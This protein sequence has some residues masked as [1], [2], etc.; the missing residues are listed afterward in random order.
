MKKY[1]NEFK[2]KRYKM[3]QDENELECE[4]EIVQTG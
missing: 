2:A 1:E 3:K 4:I